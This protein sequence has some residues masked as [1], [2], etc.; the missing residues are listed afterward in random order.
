M[1]KISSIALVG[2]TV[3]GLALAGAEH[4]PRRART[5]VAARHCPDHGRGHEVGT[6]LH[7]K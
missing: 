5:G 4:L 6:G 7:R 1:S 2:L 3:A